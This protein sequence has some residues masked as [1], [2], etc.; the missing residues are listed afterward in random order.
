[1]KSPALFI[2]LAA[3]LITSSGKSQDVRHGLV[4]L[5][6]EALDENRIYMLDS[7]LG[8][9][10][11][12]VLLR[13]AVY[14][15][16]G[17][18]NLSEIVYYG[19]EDGKM[20]EFEKEKFYYSDNGSLIWHVYYE[21]RIDTQAWLGVARSEYTYN[22][23][24]KVD[25]VINYDGYSE[26][27]KEWNRDNKHVYSY[28]VNG[29]LSTVINYDWESDIEE[30]TVSHKELYEYNGDSTLFILSY[31]DA[32]MSEWKENRKTLTYGDSNQMILSIKYNK[33]ANTGEWVEYF[34][35]KDTYQM[36]RLTMCI[37]Y[38][39]SS[40]AEDWIGQTKNEYAYNEDGSLKVKLIS[41]WDNNDSVWDFNTEETYYYH[42]D[43][44]SHIES[45]NI[46]DSQ[47]I[48]IF[49]VPTNDLLYFRGLSGNEIISIYSIT[50]K[51]ILQNLLYNNHID[52][53][54]FPDGIYIIQVWNDR[55]IKCAKKVMISK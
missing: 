5:T 10:E 36:D 6:K 48:N 16:D 45:Q 47:M 46:N 30:W 14:S 4:S 27:R 51:L 11:N 7:I 55:G 38:N 18:R 34:K 54:N 28:N 9:S 29:Q 44:V 25:T 21:I 52:V 23:A 53:T 33:D 15:Y 1:M 13:K 24:G 2:F 20:G 41:R 31:W 22:N 8:L 40:N 49:P 39:W 37:D 42:Y 12:S 19:K 3:L 32:E 17:N 50:G 26:T 35:R 43:T